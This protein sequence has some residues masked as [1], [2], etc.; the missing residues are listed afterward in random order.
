MPGPAPDRRHSD[1]ASRSSRLEP[2]HKS[3]TGQDQLDV[4]SQEGQEK[5]QVQVQNQA[6]EFNVIATREGLVGSVT[7]CS[8]QI[9]ANDHFVALPSTGL[10]NVGVTL[11]N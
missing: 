5:V 6:V 9:V 10:C 1:S 4:R 3:K 2:T 7:A 11:R 8:H